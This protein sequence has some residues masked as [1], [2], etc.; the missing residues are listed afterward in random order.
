MGSYRCVIEGD[1]RAA[2]WAGVLDRL[3]LLFDIV[4]YKDLL[5]FIT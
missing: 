2:L 3:S 5:V 4:L 1:L